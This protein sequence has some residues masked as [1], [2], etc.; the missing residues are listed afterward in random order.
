MSLYSIQAPAN[1]SQPT[2]QE[3]GFYYFAYGSC[4]CP[5][6]LKRSL[7]EST[8]AY[9]I[10]PATL[11]GYRLGFFR[12]SQLRNCGVLDIVPD[13]TASVQGVLYYLPQRLSDRLD[14]REEGYCHETVKIHCQDRVYPKTRTYTVME[15]LNEE[16][17]PNDW[18]FNVV[19]RGALTCGLPEQYCWQLF[20]HMHELQKQEFSQPLLRSS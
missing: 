10:G 13:A 4:M 8:H 16:I 17:A 7:G 5:V 11:P 19:L 12:R 9:V 15:K 14:E 18:Y 6:D 2:L 20:H 1:P 3:P